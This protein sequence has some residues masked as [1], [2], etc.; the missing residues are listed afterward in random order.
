MSD[1]AGRVID[2]GVSGRVIDVIKTNCLRRVS[3]SYAVYSETVRFM[4][5]SEVSVLVLEVWIILYSL[6]YSTII[7]TISTIIASI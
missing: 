5:M 4:S 1:V 2:V 3:V 6:N 7:T